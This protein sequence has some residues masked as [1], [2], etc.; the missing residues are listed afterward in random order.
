MEIAPTLTGFRCTLST[1]PTLRP[2]PSSC[3]RSKTMPPCN[4]CT[5][6]GVSHMR[7]ITSHELWS[8]LYILSIWIV[9]KKCNI[10]TGDPDDPTRT[11]FSTV[12]IIWKNA[13]LVIKKYMQKSVRSPHIIISVNSLK[14]AFLCSGSLFLCIKVLHKVNRNSLP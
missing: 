3:T 5:V 11:V 6:V 2:R 13:F 12:Y 4:A 9:T 10:T 14:C 7:H 1:H 8:K